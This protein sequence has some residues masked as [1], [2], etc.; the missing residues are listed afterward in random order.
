MRI[1]SAS[2]L[3]LLAATATASVTNAKKL[4][5]S[6]IQNHLSRKV[7]EDDGM[8]SNLACLTASM[9]SFSA[10][11]ASIGEITAEA[12]C[13]SFETFM[14]CD[15][16]GTDL[17]TSIRSACEQAGGK[18][19]I[20][21]LAPKESCVNELL[22]V[23]GAL[24]MIEGGDQLDLS[25]ISGVS[26]SN[27]P[28]CLDGAT[29]EDNVDVGDLFNDSIDDL[30]PLLEALEQQMA[31]GGQTLDFSIAEVLDIAGN[32]LSGDECGPTNDSF[33]LKTGLAGLMA[34]GSALFVALV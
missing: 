21:N 7:A 26:V 2:A 27:I 10:S 25:A 15:V 33:G 14:T 17:D 16:A 24:D 23:T 30:L 8:S 5:I 31:E 19:A 13:P 29:C 4:T 32:L 20:L 6:E 3:A 1:S 11:L 12:T 28:V 22:D 18:V 34:L 9:E